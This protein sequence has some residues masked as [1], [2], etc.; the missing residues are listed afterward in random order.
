[1]SPLDNLALIEYWNTKAGP[2][3]VAY[4][5]QLDRLLGRLGEQLVRHVAPQRGERV[6]DVG[7]GTGQT[8]IDLATAV[9]PS[10]KVTG[11]DVTLTM[12]EAARR[13]AASGGVDLELL[14]AD[15]QVHSFESAAY[16]AVVSRFGVMFFADPVAAFS[17]L[18]GALRSEGRLVFLCWQGVEENPW[19]QKPMAA[20]ARHVALPEPPPAGSPG[21]FS[22]GDADRTRAL[23]SKAGYRSIE[24]EDVRQA[25]VLGANVEEAFQFL[26]EIG[27]TARAL[28]EAASGDKEAALQALKH[29]L[30]AHASGINVCLDSAAWLVSARPAP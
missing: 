20:V 22:L 13:R 25:L 5:E 10:G 14:E 7:C 21:P 4:Q 1:M 27:P 9:G 24:I 28:A 6:L 15:A 18:R 16:D 23:L 2:T 29:M 8:S 30:E 17:N 19:V 11:V 3:W 12:L 26:L